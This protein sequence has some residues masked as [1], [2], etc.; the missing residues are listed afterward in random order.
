MSWKKLTGSYAMY[1]TKISQS[2]VTL[3]RTIEINMDIN[4]LRETLQR[5]SYSE[6]TELFMEYAE[7]DTDFARAFHLFVTQKMRMRGEGDARIAVDNSF[8]AIG[9]TG[10]RGNYYESMGWYTVMNDKD[11][12]FQ[13]A[14]HSFGFGNLRRA[15]AYPLQWLR[16]F[17][18]YF[19]EDAFD[20]DDDGLKFEWAC[21]EAM[22]LIEKVMYHAE[23]DSQFKEDVCKELCSLSDVWSLFEKYGWADIKMFSQHMKA[24]TESPDEALATIEGLIDK[25]GNS[26]CLSGLILQKFNILTA[27]GRGGQALD[28]LEDNIG[29]DDICTYLVN[30]LVDKKDYE[31]ALNVLEKA[32]IQDDGFLSFR[33][34]KKEIEIY[35][36]LG[37][38]QRTINAYRRLFIHNG[39]SMDMYDA[40]KS[41]IPAE[42]W[43]TYLAAMMEETHFSNYCWGSDGNTKAEIFLAENDLDSLFNY[44]ME[45][46]YNQLEHYSR[47]AI[48]LSPEQQTELIPKFVEEIRLKASAAKK[49]DHY[50]RVCGYISHL[51][52]L[53]G[54]SEVV[55]QLLNEFMEVYRRRP[56]FIAELKELICRLSR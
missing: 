15:V 19:T 26:A 39:G 17:N 23:A 8:G 1:H 40:L 44:M 14:E 18:E 25:G 32:L 31:R 10:R 54:S 49:R 4:E 9:L 7:K 27:T 12:L 3:N 11:T 47:Y 50:I 42:E 43:K 21:D 28:F 48:K 16:R 30:T 33:Y 46:N 5:L 38:K 22:K 24:L 51:K 13:D 41:M 2:N 6:L 35:E 56:A 53:H 20:Y 52:D 36:L 34:L 29:K 45:M 55:D 37:D